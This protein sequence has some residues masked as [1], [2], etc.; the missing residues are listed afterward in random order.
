MQ[1]RRSELEMLGLAHQ[2]AV[3]ATRVDAIEELS[4]VRHSRFLEEQDGRR[5]EDSERR[6]VLTGVHRVHG[7]GAELLAALKNAVTSVFQ[8][9]LPTFASKLSFVRQVQAKGDK[10]IWL[11][12]FAVRS[13]AVDIRKTFCQFMKR[14]KGNAP[15]E[16]QSVYCSASQTFSTRFRIMILREIASR[17][18]ERNPGLKVFTN[19]FTSRPVLQ[20]HP[21]NRPVEV[22]TFVD[23]VLRFGHLLSKE[24]INKTSSFARANLSGRLKEYFV[25]LNDSLPRTAPSTSGQPS[26]TSAE[27]NQANS[28]NASD[29]SMV[30]GTTSS[31]PN[32]NRKRG[33]MIDDYF[34]SSQKQRIS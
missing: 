6:L 31:T 12:D 16:I 7:H 4:A 19:P 8:K 15:T 32:E 27:A 14:E 3:T 18:A 29:A 23:S 24:F 25:V 34:T 10:Y 11:V 20:I 13:E 21:E 1:E 2:S 5:N 22:L 17:H 26:S 30:S 28:S 33:R 9:V